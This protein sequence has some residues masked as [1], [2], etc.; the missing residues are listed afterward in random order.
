MK[1]KEKSKPKAQTMLKS[2]VA[3][4]GTSSPVASQKFTPFSKAGDDQPQT[5]RVMLSNMLFFNDPNKAQTARATPQQSMNASTISY[6]PQD[7][8][9]AY[10]TS[11]KNIDI[12]TPNPK[13]SYPRLSAAP[14]ILQNT[15]AKPQMTPMT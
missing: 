15:A 3:L 11:R 7:V 8:L 9:S 10:S 12:T 14:N 4:S 13:T 1:R 6:P 2:S 5:Q